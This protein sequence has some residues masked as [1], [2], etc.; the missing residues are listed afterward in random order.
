MFPERELQPR[1]AL[2]VHFTRD[3]DGSSTRQ[4]I[5]VCEYA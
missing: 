2:E 4:E 3:K 5:A 1:T